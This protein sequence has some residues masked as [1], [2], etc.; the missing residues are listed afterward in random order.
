MGLE[1]AG[2]V[3][4]TFGLGNDAEFFFA[5]LLHPQANTTVF[6]FEPDEAKL[7]TIRETNRCLNESTK[8][9]GDVFANGT[10]FSKCESFEGI[11]NVILQDGTENLR[12]V[13]PVTIQQHQA[14]IVRLCA[15]KTLLEITS[16]KLSP[17]NLKLY[18]EEN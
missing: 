15:T 18:A 3:C 12:I 8:W 17:T 11:T 4:A 6:V 2:A 1:K 5:N 9:K 13:R 14:L 10:D 7:N 16:E